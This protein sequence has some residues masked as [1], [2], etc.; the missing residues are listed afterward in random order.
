M[1]GDWHGAAAAWAARDCPYEAARALA[2]ADDEAALR[3]AFAAF[4]RLGAR[5]AAAMVTQRLRS[6]GATSIPR[7]ARPATRANASLLTAREAEVLALIAE[8]HANAAI[9]AQLYLSR[10]TVEHHVTAILAKLG[11]SSR[12]EAVR[13]ATRS[14]QAPAN[15]GDA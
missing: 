8:G 14:H 12:Q 3:A 4:D 9:A 6:L 13:A 5:P 10:K 2:E 15:L 1:A 7:G 11:V